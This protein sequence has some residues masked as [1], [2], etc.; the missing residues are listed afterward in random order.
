[1][2]PLNYIKYVST[3]V[4][5]I[6]RL[7]NPLGFI[8]CLL[9]PPAFAAENYDLA[10]LGGRVMDPASDFDEIANVGITGDR[11]AVITNEAITGDKT[12]DA[13]GH[14][15]APGF[16]D[17]HFHGTQPLHY[18][19][20]LR[21][22]VTTAMDLEFGALGKRI[23]DWYS[24]RDGTSLINYGTSVSHELA[25]A[26][27]LDGVD[28]ID[29]SEASLTR[30][31]PNWSGL[32]PNTDEAAQ[33]LAIIDEGLKA[34]GIG[35][36]STLGYMP[37][38]SAN[39]LF[40]VQA[41]SA[42]YGR[43]IGV[44]LRHTPGTETDEIN[45]A[46]EVLANAAALNAPAIINHFNNPGWQRV[47]ELITR[48]QAQGHNVWGEIYPYAAGATTINAVFFDPS[49]W[50]DRLGRRY[51]ETMLDPSTNEFLTEQ[52][53]LNLRES[54]P[55]RVVVVFKSPEEEIVQWL[56]LDGISIASDGLPDLVPL[57]LDT[58]LTQLPNAHPR[59][60]G[61]YAKAL[62][63]ARENQLSLM[64]VLKQAST[65]SAMH[66]AAMG[67]NAMSERGK[68]QENAIADLVVFDPK[69]VTDNSTYRKGTLPSTGFKAVLVSGNLV[70]E[71]DEVLLQTTAGKPIRFAPVEPQQ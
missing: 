43:Q 13:S 71:E 64:A 56:G 39:E 70:L 69:T 52:Q 45:G 66:L 9:I 48:M 31:H 50:R 46:Q 62:R 40:E 35:V 37:G 11:I 59:T 44:H 54:D 51:E 42:S 6:R 55:T 18:R 27:V 63:L 65:T 61:T 33:I 58:D 4:T 1:M 23:D 25:R 5:L 19:I 38:A 28:A 68:V 41:L 57:P 21:M 24:E 26:S 20:A 36:G 2:K 22:G 16:I 3:R 34:G 29:T 7:F 67:L 17:T 32:V 60:A 12:I 30:I 14:V 49:N 15:I 10:I 53:Y 8:F 47:Y